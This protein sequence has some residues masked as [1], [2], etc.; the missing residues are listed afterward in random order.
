MTQC[1]MSFR[2]LQLATNPDLVERIVRGELFTLGR[3][4]VPHR[5]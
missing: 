5:Q 4:Y 2:E 3:N 1:A